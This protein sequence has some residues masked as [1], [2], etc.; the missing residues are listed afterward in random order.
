[1]TDYPTR[2]ESA[3]HQSLF[4][5]VFLP[6]PISY[7][8]CLDVQTITSDLIITLSRGEN[9]S[10]YNFCPDLCRDNEAKYVYV[11]IYRKLR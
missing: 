4:R 6:P 9:L 3:F 2:L 10:R 5:K 8:S 11:Y 1:M 7:L